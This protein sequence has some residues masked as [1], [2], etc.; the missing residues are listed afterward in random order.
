MKKFFVYMASAAFMFAACNQAE[1]EAP[2]EDVNTPV[3]TETITVD[4]NPMTKTS[5][6]GMNTVWSDGDRVSVTVGGKNIGTLELVE[7]STFSGEVEAGHNGEA[8]LNYPADVTSVPTTQT[9]VENS[10]ANGA[11]LLEGATTMDALRNGEGASLQNKTALLK[12]KSTR[13]GDVAFTI[14]TEIYTVTG[15]QVNKEYYASIAPAS[16][17]L[18]SYTL[19]GNDGTKSAT[20]TFEA[21]KIYSLG[22]LTEVFVPQE[23]FVYLKPNKNWTSAN[24]R[25]AAYFISDVWVSMEIVEGQTD[26]YQCAIPNKGFAEVIFCRMKPSTNN[27][28]DNKWDQTNDLLLTEGSLYTVA[29]GAWSKGAGSWSYDSAV[30]LK[31]GGES[32]WSLSG[33]F[34]SWGDKNMQTTTTANV[35]VAKSIKLDAYSFFKVK[36]ETNWDVNYGGGFS[37]LNPNNWTK[38]V[39]GGENMSVTKEGTYDIYFNSKEAKL[40]VVTAGAE[41]TTVSQQSSEGPTPPKVL[42]LL[43][44]SNWK[45]SNARFAAY[46]F[47]NGETWVNMTD[48]DSDG[49]YEVEVPNG[50]TKVIFCRMNPNNTTNN[51]NNKWN[52]T[53]DLTIPKDDK[54]LFTVP[55]GAWDGSTNSWSTK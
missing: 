41:Y 22:T 52:Q 19:S 47:G 20:A 31:D 53:G 36:W 55:N 21:G 43:P 32:P 1:I 17:S 45:Q 30:E 9:A 18:L 7:G 6:N 33:E 49:Y 26:I 23:G 12:F 39:S 38:V 35:Y 44:N 29:E 37:Y 8:I 15:C 40:Y 2:V 46:F 27:N 10:F 54:N 4:L 16:E 13:N 50:Y 11:A 24:A 51:W 5:L 28:W 42:Y 25:F 3:E 14:G 48:S 34:N